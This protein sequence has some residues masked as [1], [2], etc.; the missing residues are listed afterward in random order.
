MPRAAAAACLPAACPEVPLGHAFARQMDIPGFDLSS[1]IMAG[2]GVTDVAALCAAHVGCKAFTIWH[3]RDIA[4]DVV[5]HRAWALCMR[6]GMTACLNASDVYSPCSVLPCKCP[7]FMTH[8]PS[9][10]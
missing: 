2:K 6:I 4:S 3:N 9:F 5:S 10:I 8:C 7:S 1:E